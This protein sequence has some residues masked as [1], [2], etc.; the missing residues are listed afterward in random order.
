MKPKGLRLQRNMEK[1][2]FAMEVQAVCPYKAGRDR[3]VW[4]TLT[5]P[6][7]T[8]LLLTFV[9]HCSEPFAMAT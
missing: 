2:T 5:T 9:Q 8:C 3:W 7:E 6:T 1:G 4:V